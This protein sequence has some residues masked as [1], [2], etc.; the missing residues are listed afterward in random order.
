[1]SKFIYWTVQRNP[2][3]DHVT[4][5]LS[6]E[7]LSSFFVKEGSDDWEFLTDS[8]KDPWQCNFEGI[9]NSKAN[10]VPSENIRVYDNDQQLIK[11]WPDKTT[12]L[13]A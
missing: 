1:M 10:I 9:Q 7:N 5:Y 12:L 4:Q 11:A 8:G 2:E 13:T 6:K 3:V